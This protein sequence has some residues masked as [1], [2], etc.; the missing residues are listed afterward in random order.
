MRT[1]NVAVGLFAPVVKDECLDRILYALLVPALDGHGHAV[2]SVLCINPPVVGDIVAHGSGID[3]PG[4][5]Q[6]AP[7]LF[8]KYL[9]AGVQDLLG[10]L[11]IVQAVVLELTY[12]LRQGAL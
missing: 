3:M 2:D 10:V 5:H 9:G 4:A 12:Q 8:H 11:L 1:G 7:G 6:G